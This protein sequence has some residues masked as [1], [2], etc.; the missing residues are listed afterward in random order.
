MGGRDL[1]L[2]PGKWVS[3]GA[4]AKYS[5]EGL[6]RGIYLRVSRAVLEVLLFRR[7]LLL[8]RLHPSSLQVLRRIFR[9]CL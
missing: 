5:R 7:S 8:E 4:M 1:L 2:W 9:L 3:I 6:R